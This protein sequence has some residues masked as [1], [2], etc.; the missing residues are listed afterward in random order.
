MRI[1]KCTV[2]YQ[3]MEVSDNSIDR[4]NLCSD[5]CEVKWEK[6]ADW[7]RDDL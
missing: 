7:G 1:V 5:G 2:C 6:L 3:P 4:V